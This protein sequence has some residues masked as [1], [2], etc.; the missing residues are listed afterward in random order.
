MHQIP[1][2]VQNVVFESLGDAKLWIW[3]HQ[4]NWRNLTTFQRA[5]IALKLKD[6]VAAQAKETRQE[7]AATAQVSHTALDKAEYI[8]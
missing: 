7:L 8:D 1:F 4:E 3:K 6:A 2:S 5:E